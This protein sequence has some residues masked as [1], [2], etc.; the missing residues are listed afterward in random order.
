MQALERLRKSEDLS[1]AAAGETLTPQELLRRVFIHF[2]SQVALCTSFQSTG[3]VILDMAWRLYPQVRVFTIDTGRLPQET[4]D[5][6]ER[7]RERY[8]VHV[9]VYFPEAAQV[10]QLVRQHGANLFYRN[11]DLRI[12]CCQVRKVYPL[13]RVLS[14]LDAWITGLRREQNS[15]RTQVRKLEIDHEH[16]G[17]IKVNPLADWTE[18]DTWEYLRA[19]NVPYHDFYD[20]GY[21]SIGCAP[22]TRPTRAGEDPRA[23]RWWWETDIPKECGLHYIMNAEGQ[24]ECKANRR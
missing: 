24:M 10:E 5:L 3:M 12:L 19:H 14:T 20:K 8:G 16:G 11:P 13:Q 1:W 17:V 23:G 6:M 22:C 18:Q 4:Y 7:V 21:T 2:G 9:E 15:T